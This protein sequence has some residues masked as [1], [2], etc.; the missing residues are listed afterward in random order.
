MIDIARSVTERVPVFALPG[1]L[2]RKPALKLLQKL[3]H[4]SE[5]NASLCE[6]R[7]VGCLDFIDQLFD[8]FNFTYQI[9]ARDRQ[10]IPAQGR[11]VIIANQPLASL[12][13]LA[14]LRLVGEFRRDIKL[15][16]E[17]STNDL[18][19]LSPLVIQSNDPL[20]TEQMVV[21]ALDNEQAVI[22][23][24]AG[25]L[26]KTRQNASQKARWRPEFLNYCRQTQTP[27]LPVL[28]Q[29]QKRFLA[30]SSDLLSKPLKPLLFRNRAVPASIVKFR[31]G[32]LISPGALSHSQLNDR[33]LLQRIK[34][35]LLKLR[36]DA[37]SNF[38]TVKTI[39]HPEDRGELQKELKQAT[40]L[41]E[42]RDNNVIYL[43]SFDSYTLMLEI[44]RMREYT[45]RKV[46]EG[47]GSRRDLDTYD[48]DYHHLVLW[49]QE[50]LEIAGAYRL[51]HVKTL[52]RQHGV[53]GLYTSSLFNFLPAFSPFLPEAV[54][55]GRSFV[56]PKYWGKN[57]LDY[58]WQG[59]GAYFRHNP[60]VR[61]VFG[62]VTISADYP[63][64]LT[65]ELVFYYEHYFS[66]KETLAVGKMPFTIA[67]ERHQALTEKYRGLEKD[68]GMKLLQE[69]FSNAGY[70]MPVLFKQYA[71]LYEEGGFHLLAFNID[72]DFSDCIDGLFIADL[73][74][75]KASKR[76]RYIG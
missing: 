43:A 74:K 50:Q 15:V 64:V 40:V 69:T 19:C 63:M 37:I 58:L 51:G 71:S 56:S 3:T 38:V 66:N 57:S 67:R 42:T 52:M 54:E 34:K 36:R 73:T 55:L 8:K 44:G 72:P 20:T 39:A 11:V 70:K 5:F 2:L 21:N 49:N 6:Q 33:A 18:M 62:P 61:Y 26:A 16:V 76:K 68:E 9:S 35:H 17:D 24:P 31:V 46:G 60:D 30:F 65:E 7:G 47:T 27:V 14:V 1:A 22:I 13:A 28:I 59:I 12:D 48:R 53:N 45:F 4:E 32:E 75:L 29:R 10:N 23:F 41:G 25:G